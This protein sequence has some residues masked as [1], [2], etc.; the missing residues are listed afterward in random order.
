MQEMLNFPVQIRIL[1][2]AALCY[3]SLQAQ[4]ATGRGRG[5]GVQRRAAA[6]S[7]SHQDLWHY[8]QSSGY[9]LHYLGPGNVGKCLE[10]EA[11]NNPANS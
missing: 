4:F 10:A 9:L 6:A 8:N 1:S 2:S 5:V 11:G 7:G 3:T